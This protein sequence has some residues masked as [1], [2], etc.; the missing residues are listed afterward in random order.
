[1]GRTAEA[2]ATTG[3]MATATEMG[4]APTEVGSTATHVATPTPEMSAAAAPTTAS[5]TV[6]FSGTGRESRDRCHGQNLQGPAEKSC[7]SHFGHHGGFTRS[8]RTL[9]AAYARHK[10]PLHPD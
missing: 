6:G 2:G 10:Y 7:V 5:R 3:E 1:M 9:K 4:A 8:L